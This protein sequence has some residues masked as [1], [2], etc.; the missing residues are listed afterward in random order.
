MRR[1]A[2]QH[3]ITFCCS[4]LRTLVQRWYH[5]IWR[6]RAD[7]GC[8]AGMQPV[9]C[10]GC[11]SPLPPPAAIEPA[12][13]LCSTC[14]AQALTPVSWNARHQLAIMLAIFHSIYKHSAAGFAAPHMRDCF[15]SAVELPRFDFNRCRDHRAA[16]TERSRM[17]LAKPAKKTFLFS[18]AT[19]YTATGMYL[20]HKSQC[21]P[22]AR[23]RGQAWHAAQRRHLNTTLQTSTES[24]NEGCCSVP[25]A[26]R[27]E[28]MVCSTNCAIK[29]M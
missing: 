1:A 26:S 25:R 20:R 28:V 16:A 15:I 4:D 5:R 17:S 18:C 8:R 9:S 29:H 14:I 3:V 6:H 2:V 23:G 11:T 7:S 13:R 27:V 22:R 19:A 21:K 12:R 10:R 24:K